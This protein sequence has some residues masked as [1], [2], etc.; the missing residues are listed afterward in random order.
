MAAFDLSTL[1]DS[2]TPERPDASTP[3]GDYADHLQYVED[4]VPEAAWPRIE[5]RLAS[6]RHAGT[7][8]HYMEGLLALHR[9]EH[10]RALGLFEKA[11]A[12]W[13]RATAP[14]LGYV[15]ACYE[16]APPIDT[17]EAYR[18]RFYVETLA[19]GT[20]SPAARALLDLDDTFEFLGSGEAF[21]ATTRLAAATDASRGFYPNELLLLKGYAALGRS[22]ATVKEVEARKA[23]LLARYPRLE[24]LGDAIYRY[25]APSL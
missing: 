11:I 18:R 20:G 4:D 16:L 13:P 21:T 23:A 5:D 19:A 25:A 9:N 1:L 3:R 15:T 6:L 22:A 8:L 12:E 24:E 14:R 2:G 10:P 7:P 17:E